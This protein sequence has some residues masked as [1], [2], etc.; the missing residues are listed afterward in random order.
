MIGLSM[1]DPNLRRLLDISAKNLDKPR[2]FAFIRRISHERFCFKKD[3][4]GTSVQVVQNLDAAE[5]F[6][7][8]H[9]KLS[10]DLMRELGITVIWYEDHDDIPELLDKF[11]V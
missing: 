1:T 8:G 4:D 2:H 3:K 11:R 10:E 7:E 6:L 5:N 9:H